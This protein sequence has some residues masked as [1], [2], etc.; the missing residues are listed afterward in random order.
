MDLACMANCDRF[1]DGLPLPEVLKDFAPLPVRPLSVSQPGAATKARLSR[2]RRA[3]ASKSAPPRPP[4]ALRRPAAADKRLAPEMVEDISEGTDE[5][6]PAG[7]HP[8]GGRRHRF[9]KEGLAGGEA[10]AAG[11]MAARGRAGQDVAARGGARRRGHGSGLVLPAPVDAF[12]EVAGD[13]AP[14]A[15]KRRRREG[16]EAQASPAGAPAA[17]AA[18][19]APPAGPADAPPGMYAL[20]C[21]KCRNNPRGCAVCLRAALA[22]ARG[23]AD[24]QW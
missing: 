10:E 6:T 20:G 13:V 1:A 7:G 16:G 8:T 12:A 22:R 23:Q 17:A 18:A 21:G 15:K 3:T 2:D 4:I 24:G 14:S 9:K 19:R 5:D 11:P